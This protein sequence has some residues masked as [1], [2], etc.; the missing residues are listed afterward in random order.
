M[1]TMDAVQDAFGPKIDAEE[2]VRL[3]TAMEKRSPVKPGQSAPKAEK[4]SFSSFRKG[5]WRRITTAFANSTDDGS[6]KTQ[7]FRGSVVDRE[8]QNSASDFQASGGRLS[9]PTK[10]PTCK[11]W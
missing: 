5:S 4:L 6:M 7:R 11:A 2:A 1:E 10:E 8:S 3:L 9:C